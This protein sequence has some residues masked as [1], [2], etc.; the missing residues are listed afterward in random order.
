MYYLSR[1][2]AIV[3]S[4]QGRPQILNQGRS[5]VDVSMPEWPGSNARAAVRPHRRPGPRKSTPAGR[6]AAAL[7]KDAEGGDTGSDSW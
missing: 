4:P 7:D 3:E 5:D 6:R 2:I 1:S